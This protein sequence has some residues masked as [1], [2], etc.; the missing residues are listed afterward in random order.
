MKRKR[1]VKTSFLLFLRSIG[2]LCKKSVSS[3]KGLR[4]SKSI[5]PDGAEIVHNERPDE[6][7]KNIDDLDSQI[8]VYHEIRKKK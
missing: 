6:P 2:M 7:P 1:N 5:M 3:A 8:H 4:I